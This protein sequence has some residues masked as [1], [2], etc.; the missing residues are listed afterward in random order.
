MGSQVENVSSLMSSCVISAQDRVVSPS[1]QNFFQLTVTSKCFY[2][3]F[4]LIILFFY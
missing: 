4:D 1:N 2:Y 3:F